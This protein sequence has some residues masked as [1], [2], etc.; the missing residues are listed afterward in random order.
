MDKRGLSCGKCLDSH[1]EAFYEAVDWARKLYADEPMKV[2]MVQ[3]RGNGY[4]RVIAVPVGKVRPEP[5]C[6]EE[7][8]HWVP[9]DQRYYNKRRLVVSMCEYCQ[10]RRVTLI[11]R[12]PEPGVREPARHTLVRYVRKK[13]S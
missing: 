1:L 4:K 8:H 10:L 3:V 12:D 6:K 5:P 7:A 9:E 2:V 13:A 11:G